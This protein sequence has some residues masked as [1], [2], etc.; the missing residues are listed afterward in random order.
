MTG[1]EC[2][3]IKAYVQDKLDDLHDFFFQLQENGVKISVA[4]YDNILMNAMLDLR[5]DLQT[6]VENK[7][8]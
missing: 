7:E 6:E 8:E 5:C 3:K 1:Q 4:Q 2:N